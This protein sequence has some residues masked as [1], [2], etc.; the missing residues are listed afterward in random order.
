MVIERRYTACAKTI[1]VGEHAVVHGAEAVA[2][3]LR[4]MRLELS[5]RQES[6]PASPRPLLQMELGGQQVSP[7]LLEAAREAARLLDVR[8]P[9]LRISGTSTILV[10]AG[11][12]SSAALCVALLRAMAG[13]Y[14]HDI[15][16]DD[17]ARLANRLEQAFH[18]T[19]SGLDTNVVAR[20]RVI[21]FT[22]QNGPVGVNVSGTWNFALIDSGERASTSTMI[23]RVSP[24]FLDKT[25]GESRIHAFNKL[26]SNACSALSTANHLLLADVM[27]E[28]SAR[29]AEA[30]AMTPVLH[31]LREAAMASGALGVKVTGAGGGGCLLALLPGERPDAVCAQLDRHL[32]SRPL[33][34]IKLKEMREQER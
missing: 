33:I 18:G 25:Q 23:E 2:M 21:R 4:D 19:P 8:D 29:L 3:P 16:E 6:Q 28:A 15:E 17:L 20:E 34:P 24:W 31:E 22:R 12:G 11:L 14:G 27:N 10:G 7:Q 5:V 32:G 30:G 1:L 13:V 9:G 26:A